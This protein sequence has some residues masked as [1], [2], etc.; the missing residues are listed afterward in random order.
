[1]LHMQKIYLKRIFI[2]SPI[3]KAFNLAIKGFSFHL[4]G[5]DSRQ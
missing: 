1:M 2:K 5:L 4:P 3:K